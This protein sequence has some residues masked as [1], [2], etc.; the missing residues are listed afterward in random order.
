MAEATSQATRHPVAS[1]T[2]VI[3]T[4][5]SGISAAPLAVTSPTARPRRRANQYDTEVVAISVSP[6]CP[7]MR[8]P[9]KPTVRVTSPWTP[10][11][12]VSTTPNRPPTRVMA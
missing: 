8:M 10:A 1:I 12:A 11:I 5:V 7:S 3:A 6:P 4:G 9:R 2:V